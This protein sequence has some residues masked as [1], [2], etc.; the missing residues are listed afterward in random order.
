MNLDEM[1]SFDIVFPPF[2]IRLWIANGFEE[3]E[4]ALKAGN[5]GR[6]WTNAKNDSASYLYNEKDVSAS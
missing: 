1:T 4:K 2:Q 3:W 5:F 6:R